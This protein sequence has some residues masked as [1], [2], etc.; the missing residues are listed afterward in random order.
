MESQSGGF[1]ESELVRSAVVQKLSVIGE[2]ASRLSK[3][4]RDRQAGIPWP[5]VIAFRDLLIHA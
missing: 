2:A 4:F 3:D 1:R 5:Q